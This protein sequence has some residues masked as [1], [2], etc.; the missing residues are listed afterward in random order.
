MDSASSGISN[1]V[2]EISKIGGK[3]GPMVAEGMILLLIVLR[4]VTTWLEF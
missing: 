3:P 4:M 2:D 1:Y